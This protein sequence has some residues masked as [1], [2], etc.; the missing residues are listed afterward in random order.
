MKAFMRIG[1]AKFLKFRRKF[2]D[3]QMQCIHLLI[4]SQVHPSLAKED[5]TLIFGCEIPGQKMHTSYH[6]ERYIRIVFQR[7]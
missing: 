5:G 3:K 4:V 6:T 7:P 1:I 2:V